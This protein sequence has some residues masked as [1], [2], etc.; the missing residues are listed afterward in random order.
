MAD[1]AQNTLNALVSKAELVK[2]LGSIGTDLV[3]KDL[4]DLNISFDG[5]ADA[6]IS[7]AEVK[8]FLFIM[9]HIPVILIELILSIGKAC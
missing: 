9:L 4:D 8:I 7:K 2:E 6:L 3:D 5:L 1:Q